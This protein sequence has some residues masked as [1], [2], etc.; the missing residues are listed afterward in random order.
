MQPHI[1]TPWIG[2]AALVT[3]FAIPFLPSWLFEGPRTVKHRPHRH[4]CAD[5]GAPWQDGH[6][7]TSR[8]DSDEEIVHGQ[9]ERMTVSTALESRTAPPVESDNF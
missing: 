5:C 8:I 9:L 7:C 3:M 6:L 4:V 1:D 2:L